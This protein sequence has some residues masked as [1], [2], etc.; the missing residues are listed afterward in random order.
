[1]IKLLHRAV[2]TSNDAMVKQEANELTKFLGVL[3]ETIRIENY[4]I[5]FKAIHKYGVEEVSTPNKCQECK[6]WRI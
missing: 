2:A 4:K 5:E 1:M 3:N 6:K